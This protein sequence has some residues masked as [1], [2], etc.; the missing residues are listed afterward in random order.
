M[1]GHRLVFEQEGVLEVKDFAPCSVQG[2]IWLVNKAR[3]HTTL[4]DAVLTGG[5]A[6]F[7]GQK[8]RITVTLLGEAATCGI[9]A[10]TDHTT[11]GHPSFEDAHSHGIWQ[12][13][14]CDWLRLAGKRCT[15]PKGAMLDLLKHLPTHL[16]EVRPLAGAY[17]DENRG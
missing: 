11:A 15:G 10:D 17:P 5:G 3:G 13:D 9:Y 8:V 16:Y 14:Q 2:H 12:F 7:L 4:A 1:D 6:A